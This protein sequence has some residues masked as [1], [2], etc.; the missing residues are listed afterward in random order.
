MPPRGPFGRIQAAERELVQEAERGA[1]AEVEE[2]AA[3]E[4]ERR[5]GRPGRDMGL[6]VAEAVRGSALFLTNGISRRADQ[7]DVM[8]ERPSSRTAALDESWLPRRPG[9]SRVRARAPGLGRPSRASW[10]SERVEL[11]PAAPRVGVLIIGG[12]LPSLIARPFSGTL[13]KKAKN[14]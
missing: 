14:L 4:L 3:V 9:P 13:L 7:S 1:V 6:S 2:R 5:A 12:E 10:F 11:V 8:L